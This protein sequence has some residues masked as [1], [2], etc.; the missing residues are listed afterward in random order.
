MG[1]GDL[2]RLQHIYDII[3]NKKALYRS[4]QVYLETK[5]Q[6]PTQELTPISIESSKIKQVF[7]YTSSLQKEILKE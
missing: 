6:P 7:Q 1:G 5:L 3:A 4:D 2:G